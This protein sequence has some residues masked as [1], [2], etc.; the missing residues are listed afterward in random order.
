MWV[1]PRHTNKDVS[2]EEKGKQKGKKEGRMGDRQK[3][4]G[5]ERDREREREKQKGGEGGG[6]R[7]GEVG[8]SDFAF[9]GF[10]FVFCATC[11]ATCTIREILHDAH[12]RQL[13]REQLRTCCAHRLTNLRVEWQS[14]RAQ[15]VHDWM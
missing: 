11:H 12:W 7:E 3:G 13:R 6:G 10:V 4:G 8:Y 2:R 5:R 1:H 9:V 15:P 14:N